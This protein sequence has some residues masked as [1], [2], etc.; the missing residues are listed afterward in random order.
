MKIYF[1]GSISGGRKH[2]GTYQQIV[3]H[4]KS[5][6]HQVLTEHVAHPDVLDKEK[7]HTAEQ[8]YTRDIQWIAECDCIIAEVS[9][10]SLGVG[11]EVCHALEM[12]KP[13]LCIHKKGVF[14]SRMI[15]G[16][17]SEV[18]LV[19]EYENEDDWRKIIYLFFSCF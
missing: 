15:T 19:K 1:S 3:A 18:L 11:Y 17:N 7:E 9:N 5:E 13:V 4:L 16:N 12:Y 6:G 14:M 8:I 2:L 10:P